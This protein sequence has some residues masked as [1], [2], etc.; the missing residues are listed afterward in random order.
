MIHEMMLSGFAA[1][2]AAFMDQ[3]K[4]A[5]RPDVTKLR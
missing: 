3:D 2:R 5:N 1:Y 4:N